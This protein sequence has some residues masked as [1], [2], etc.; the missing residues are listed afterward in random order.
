MGCSR[1]R[2][3]S[4][5]ANV[6]RCENAGGLCCALAKWMSWCRSGSC[7]S[8][9]WS[10]FSRWAD[11]HQRKKPVRQCSYFV[12]NNDSTMDCC[13]FGGMCSTWLTKISC[14]VYCRFVGLVW[15]R[16]DICEVV[17]VY[18]TN[19]VVRGMVRLCPRISFSVK[20]THK[21]LYTS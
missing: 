19:E 8:D 18:E 14:G 21:Y 4:V 9:G 17:K 10:D 16:Y 20:K 1:S 5:C 13:C 11:G 2:K 7:W 6:V 15:L 3:L 12:R